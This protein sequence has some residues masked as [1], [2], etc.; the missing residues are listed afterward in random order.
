MTFLFKRGLFLYH[1][2]MCVA[3]PSQGTCSLASRLTTMSLE[4]YTHIC[5]QKN[6]PGVQK[7]EAKSEAPVS[8]YLYIRLKSVISD[9]G[10]DL[11]AFKIK[12]KIKICLLK[13]SIAIDVQHLVPLSL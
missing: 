1:I 13:Y 5:K 7:S 9:G 11:F 6:S 2:H 8:S 4:M 12:A 10:Q 3:C